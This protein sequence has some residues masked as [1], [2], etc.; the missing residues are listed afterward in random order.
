MQYVPIITKILSSQSVRGRTDRRQSRGYI[1]KLFRVLSLLEK[2]PQALRMMG[3]HYSSPPAM[4]IRSS[5]Q[6]EWALWG[7]WNFKTS[8][9][10]GRTEKTREEKEGGGSEKGCFPSENL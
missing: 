3:N 6:K 10:D 4:N 7:K 8:L 9:P 5:R 1:Q 2:T